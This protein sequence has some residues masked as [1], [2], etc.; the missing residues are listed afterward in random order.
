MKKIKALTSKLVYR[1]VCAVQEMKWFEKIQW[2][3]LGLVLIF[4]FFTM[5]YND[6]LYMITQSY[7]ILEMLVKGENAWWLIFSS[8]YGFTLF[9]VYMIWNV[10]MLFV[11]AILGKG[12]WLDQ[13]FPVLYNKVLLLIV[14]V[15][16]LYSIV[17]IYRML[18][19]SKKQE[20]L[21]CFTTM[22]SAFY[23]LTVVQLTQYDII[24]LSIGLLGLSY[25]LEDKNNLFLL[26]FAIANPM[27]YLTVMIFIPLV[28]LK[29]KNLI[30]AGIQMLEGFS[31]IG[32]NIIMRKLLTGSFGQVYNSMVVQELVG[33]NLSEINVDSGLTSELMEFLNSH[34]ELPSFL[35]SLL[36]DIVLFV[37][38]YGMICILAY[39]I[40]WKK[41]NKQ[42][43]IY[44]PFLV[45][46][47]FFL[48]SDWP[49]YRGIL[50]CPFMVL[51]IFLNAQF[52]NLGLL[53]ELGLSIAMCFYKV[54]EAAWVIGGEKTFE[55]LVLKGKT[56]HPNM[57]TMLNVLYDYQPY[58]PFIKTVFVAILISMIV[59][60][61]PKV[62]SKIQLDDDKPQQVLLWGRVM[63]IAGWTFMTAYTLLWM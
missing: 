33:N 23:M 21:L 18:G 57:A 59:L 13:V 6:V 7:A 20:L 48:L 29:E 8:N 32:F 17:K 54:Q 47:S 63:F 12:F 27:K 50:I 2:A 58:L 52:I 51:L 44:L 61:C 24:G 1:I 55:W 56:I 49:A 14:T 30:K 31:L 41:C 9:A 28:L 62:S 4:S 36:S 3:I 42:W 22:T 15:V 16:M 53:L 46:A 19:C 60:Y 35:R 10:P 34:Q 38:A 26:A 25:Y 37:L 11:R 45:F 43:A 5:C 39:A 40:N